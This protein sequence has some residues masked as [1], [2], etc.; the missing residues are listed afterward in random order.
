MIVFSVY[1]II[2]NIEYGDAGTPDHGR[3]G[4]NQFKLAVSL[5]GNQRVTFVIFSL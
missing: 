1:N 4:I 2:I 3:F 5:G